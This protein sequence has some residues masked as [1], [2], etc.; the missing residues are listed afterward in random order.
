MLVF[1]W[2]KIFIDLLEKKISINIFSLTFDEIIYLPSSKMKES[3][4]YLRLNEIIRF[5]P[6]ENYFVGRT[7]M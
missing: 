6:K 4:P 3:L 2:Q 5:L 7:L 1:H